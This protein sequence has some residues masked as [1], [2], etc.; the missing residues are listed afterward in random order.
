[1]TDPRF[2]F[3]TRVKVGRKWF[4][5]VSIPDPFDET[6]YRWRSAERCIM[7]ELVDP[8]AERRLSRAPYS[9][10][11]ERESEYLIVKVGP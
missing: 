3:G 8:A 10:P 9:P 1:M 4:T 5:V 7:P 11:P 2:R 6:L